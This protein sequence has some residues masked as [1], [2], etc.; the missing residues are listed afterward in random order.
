ML[1]GLVLFAVLAV[2]MRVAGHLRV[3]RWMRLVLRVERR[4]TR[5]FEAWYVRGKYGRRK[6]MYTLR[7]RIRTSVVGAWRLRMCVASLLLIM[8]NIA[9]YH[10]RQVAK[11]LLR[12]AI[13]KA[14]ADALRG[15]DARTVPRG[16]GGTPTPTPRGQAWAPVVETLGEVVPTPADGSCWIWA[17]AGGMGRTTMTSMVPSESDLI[18]E[19][20]WR[21]LV[22]GVLHDASTGDSDRDT[23]RQLAD[24]AV[25][26]A[27]RVR[28][29]RGVLCSRGG[30]ATFRQLQTLATVLNV[31][32]VVW[33]VDSVE[34]V[35]VYSP[36]GAEAVSLLGAD[37]QPRFGL[38]GARGT[39][40][41][42][43]NGED[44]FDGF[45]DGWIPNEDAEQEENIHLD[46]EVD[47]VQLKAA[48]DIPRDQGKPVTSHVIGSLAALAELPGGREISRSTLVNMKPAAL[49]RDADVVVRIRDG[50]AK[51]S[52]NPHRRDAMTGEGTG[53]NSKGRD[54]A[55]YV[56][57]LVHVCTRCGA[58]VSRYW[59]CVAAFN[60]G[61]S[62]LADGDGCSSRQCSK[63]KYWNKEQFVKAQLMYAVELLKDERPLFAPP[64]TRGDV[65]AEYEGTWLSTT[66]TMLAANRA[67]RGV[68]GWLP[69]EAVRVAVVKEEEGADL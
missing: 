68:I 64:R 26:A 53:A 59:A 28:Y 31:H 29:Q 20:D 40:H 9:M 41:V 1:E 43:W 47:T 30:E 38:P 35:A 4:H 5:I 6:R 2:T 46:M 63:A 14:V 10:A 19:R 61:R 45:Q 48:Q 16:G 15:S 49:R 13:A 11:E 44:H 17:I 52:G 67:I 32:I 60:A 57:R 12:K 62:S 34:S 36:A 33:C 23:S 56:R 25:A 51:D 50:N 8:Q 54:N 69:G 42:M 65:G 27:T 7:R 24:A 39:A 37:G 21:T 3:V 18:L 66:S 22:A 55:Q 58:L